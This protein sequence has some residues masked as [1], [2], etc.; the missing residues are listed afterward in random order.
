VLCQIC[1]ERPANVHLT[2][3]VNGEKQEFHICEQCAKEKEGLGISNGFAE[4][5]V[6]FSFS[7]ILAGLMD[8]TGSMPYTAQKQVKCPGCDLGYDDFKK[9]GRLGCSQCY[10]VYGDRLEPLLKRIHGNTQHTGK[11]PRRTGGIIRVKRDIEKLK[12]ELKK[13]I[14]EEEYEKAAQ[15]RDRIKDLEGKDEEK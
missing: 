11:V 9:T 6:P 2:K 8:F 1:N 3:I 5:D 12:Y 7:N 10:E 15:L 13:A 14:E 4:F